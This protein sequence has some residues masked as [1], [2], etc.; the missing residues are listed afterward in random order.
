MARAIKQRMPH[1]RLVYFGDTAHLPYG[2]KSTASIQAYSI[3]IADV[4]L[5]QQCK[6][7]LIACNSA[8]AAAYELVKAYVASK[9]LVMNV[10]DPMV[11]HL[12]EQHAGQRVGLIGTRQTVTSNTY[13]KRVDALG[14]NITLSAL[15]TPLLVPLIEEGFANNPMSQGI[16]EAYL[17]HEALQNIQALVLGCTHYPLLKQQIGQYYQTQRAMQQSTP[18][19]GQPVA[20]L[21]SADMAAKALQGL[22]AHHA[23]LSQQPPETPD[24]FMVSDLTDN[25]EAT[26]RLF[27]NAPVR[28]QKY[29]LWE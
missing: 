29:P 27:F 19:V 7:I 3:K 15:A 28:L 2:D 9:A 25:F 11:N 26:T 5:Q 23:L 22:L 1:E 17:G 12:R 21:D 16:I 4:L 24:L 14:R 6:V 10:I 18:P 8:S 20:V 13:K